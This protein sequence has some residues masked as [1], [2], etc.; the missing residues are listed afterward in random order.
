MG[1]TWI[2][3]AL[4]IAAIAGVV[5]LYLAQFKKLAFALFVVLILVLPTWIATQFVTPWSIYRSYVDTLTN[6]TGLN[7][8]LITAA[9]SILFIPFYYAYRMLLH[10]RTRN[11]G[12]AILLIML[13]GYNVSLYYFT[14][15]A[16]FAFDS[17]K[18]IKWFVL[19]PEGVEFSDRPG[20][21]PKYGKPYQPVTADNVRQL[22]LLKQG[23]FNPID[24]RTATFFNPI[25]G[26]PQL[27][28]YRYSDG[29]LEFYDKPGFHP[30]TGTGLEVVTR[31]VY[32]TWQ[33]S[34]SQQ[35]AAIAAASA[36]PTPLGPKQDPL[37]DRW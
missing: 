30:Q 17:G 20:V 7:Q 31:D 23:K 21:H 10:H 3:L 32:A 29:R 15:N 2:T 27:W 5:G 14:H 33:D 8:Y 6:L 36:P 9:A 18:A 37:Q 22:E 11:A 34:L 24:P 12:I 28:Y 19:T 4:A 16:Y 13:A 1:L 25:T 26:D 35:A